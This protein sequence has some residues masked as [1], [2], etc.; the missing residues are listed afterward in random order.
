MLIAGRDRWKILL[1][2]PA[3]LQI[4]LYLR[5][6]AGLQPQVDPDIP[7]LDPPASVW[8][9]WVR[10]PSGSDRPPPA[11]DPVAAAAQWAR[12]WTHLL[13]AGQSAFSELRPPNFR[14][15][16]GVPELRDLLCHHWWDAEAWTDG[17]HD[18]PRRRRDLSGPWRALGGV[19]QE[20]EQERG[21][22]AADFQLRVTVI[23][24]VGKR[25]WILRPDHLLV[26]RPLMADQD[27]AVDWLR[28]RIRV[29]I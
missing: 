11:V 6:V 20:L 10:R 3:V 14:A 26:T 13:Q 4:A 8:P 19:V 9:A 24:V 27:N 15:F 22:S 18:D 25:G 28:M 1:E 17:L 2:E 23:P 7:P 21:G 16:S 5:D 12:W 29:L